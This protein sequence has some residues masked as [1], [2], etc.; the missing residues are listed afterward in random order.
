MELTRVQTDALVI[1]GGLAGLSAALELRARGWD[2]TI[3]SKGKVGQ[4][5]NTI[6]TRNSMAAVLVEAPTSGTV[7]EHVQ[8]TLVGGAYLNDRELVRKLAA[9]AE[10]GIKSLERWGVPFLRQ[11]GRISSKG[12]PG[13][14]RERIVTVDAR[15]LRSTHNAGLALSLPLLEKAKE[16]G[17]TLL[18][19]IL[20]TGLLK[21][22]GTV[23][24]AYGLDRSK[25]QAWVFES[26]VVI[27]ASGGVGKLYP[28][29]TNAGDVSGDGYALG[30]LAGAKVR[31][32]EFIQFHPTVSMVASKE[33]LSTA[34]LSA[35]AVLRNKLGDAFMTRYS[36][37]G[38][39]ATRDV[40]ARAVYEEIKSGRGSDNGGV[41]VDYSQVSP[42][43]MAKEYEPIQR[44]LNGR[45]TIEV[46]TAA[47]FMMGGIVI[48]EFG[49]TGVPG[50][51]ACGEVTGGVHG[52]N[53]LA[54]NALTEAVVFGIEAGRH[55]G[56][57]R[58]PGASVPSTLKFTEIEQLLAQDG[59][60]LR[61]DLPRVAEG[62]D[63]QAE[64]SLDGI[65]REM[66]SLMGL[67]VGIVR[68]GPGLWHTK[69]KLG[70]FQTYLQ[71][72]PCRRYSELLALSQLKLMILTALLITEAAWERQ[73]SL[74]AHYRVD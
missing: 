13:H 16:A 19:G 26:R 38:D 3:V 49:R 59:I 1:G 30:Y 7:I 37:E 56:S 36:P 5:G 42:A 48:D 10:E 34:P 66:R 40:M 39:M 33:V 20:I 21:Q 63:V 27:L 29:T 74:G 64:P 52:A 70:Q 53:R 23:G 71:T 9:K 72:Y 45:S 43:K 12:S 41:Y 58:D 28:L 31:D 44:R 61:H 14:G 57:S 65:K 17:V 62:N 67:N 60:Y 35:G 6:M 54:G 15:H 4:S 55:A 73:E 32:M 50:L 18:N 68:S 24:G 47:H 51:Y 2:V 8:D 25:P 46:G 69:E 22:D 11:D